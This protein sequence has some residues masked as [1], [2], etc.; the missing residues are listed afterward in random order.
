[1]S[2]T[3]NSY[4]DIKSFERKFDTIKE[5]PINTAKPI[6]IVEDWI[7]HRS[8]H[9]RRGM[10]P[11]EDQRMVAEHEIRKEII[12]LTLAKQN[13]ELKEKYDNVKLIMTS[14]ILCIKKTD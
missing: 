5:D 1:M 7:L 4:Y 14:D 13:N 2:L 12:L 9:C 6:T 10:L 8:P 11:Q 3:T